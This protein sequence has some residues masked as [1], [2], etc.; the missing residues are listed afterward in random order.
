MLTNSS[1]SGFWSSFKSSNLSRIRRSACSNAIVKA[2]TEDCES[3]MS[4]SASALSSS[5]AVSDSL[6]LFTCHDHTYLRLAWKSSGEI[7]TS[8]PKAAS[9][10]AYFS[11]NNSEILAIPCVA[12]SHSNIPV[13]V[14]VCKFSKIS[15]NSLATAQ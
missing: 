8:T 12:L 14:V 2:S 5:R 15:S 1:H 9:V 6:I 11:C 7:G 13:A 3:S 4:R 10:L